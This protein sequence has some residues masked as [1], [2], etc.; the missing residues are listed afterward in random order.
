MQFQYSA[1]NVD[2]K[3]SSGFVNAENF[4]KAK[5]QLESMGFSIDYLKE[6]NT[7][8]KTSSKFAKYQFKGINKEGKTVKGTIEAEN[9]EQGLI[10]LMDEFEL[11]VELFGDNSLSPE[12][13]SQT[14][15]SVA[16]KTQEIQSRPKPEKPS[17]GEEKPSNFIVHKE[18]DY[19][20]NLI[21][22]INYILNRFDSYLRDI[23]K[24]ELQETL[25]IFEKTR[26]SENKKQIQN[27]AKD[28]IYEILNDELFK[29]DFDFENSPE[30][31][32]LHIQATS[33]LFLKANPIERILKS[34]NIILTTK[35]NLTRKLIWLEIIKTF[36]KLI[37]PK[38]QIKKNISKGFQI[39]TQLEKKIADVIFII[40][41]AYLAFYFLSYLIGIKLGFNFNI[42]QTSFI[43]YA[44]L[45]GLFIQAGLKFDLL[46]NK[47]HST[48]SIYL[49]LIFLSLYVILISKL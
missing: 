33:L 41:Q 45:A 31:N 19:V 16:E 35:S 21:S 40:T 10:R 46:I 28:L 49:I 9:V 38:P 32:N 14:S 15:D 6:T 44:I 27:Q 5:S 18:I 47:K 13:L 17:N 29:P 43:I 12:E 1:T 24:T 26:Y 8:T 25:Q 48:N 2:G 36:K 22:M 4:D 42:Y 3:T 37:R 20:E 30:I 34:V 39:D 7:E 23:K 11:K